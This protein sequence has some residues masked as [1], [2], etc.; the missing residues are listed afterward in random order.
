M[1]DGS[2]EGREL[3]D[4]G[5]SVDVRE[6]KSIPTLKSSTIPV[7]IGTKRNLRSS[8]NQATT[9]LPD[10][11]LESVQH[12]TNSI[13][14]T[15]DDPSPTL[16]DV[17]VSEPRRSMRI[18]TV[19]NLPVSATS[20][21]STTG[22]KRAIRFE[23]LNTA[24]DV[25]TGDVS[26]YRYLINTRHRDDED[27]LVYQVTNVYVLSNTKD[28]VG[29]RA[30]VLRDGSLFRKPE[31]DPIHVRDLAILTARYAKERES[32]LQCNYASELLGNDSTNSVS[33]SE[34]RDIDIPERLAYLY[35]SMSSQYDHCDHLV[36]YCLMALSEKLT[37]PTPTTR[38]QALASDHKEQWLAAR[39][40]RSTLLLGRKYLNLRL[41]PQ[42]RIF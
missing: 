26:E 29:D 15:N 42:I 6:V 22:S 23:H 17:P 20:L 19:S 38:R 37:I 14:S 36:E 10:N 11:S 35:N 24:S 30:L 18:A 2:N 28:I 1:G 16:S 12:D 7:N 40:R 5:E 8:S 21:S 34:G 41:N 25:Q 13:A 9:S 39:K 31:Y 33:D 3:V 27:M 32:Q 4:K